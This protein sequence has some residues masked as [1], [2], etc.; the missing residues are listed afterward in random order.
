MTGD[1]RGIRRR[2]AVGDERDGAGGGL[3]LGGICPGTRASTLGR[4][5]DE[6]VAHVQGESELEDADGN[7]QEQPGDHDELGHGRPTL[8][9]PGPR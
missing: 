2:Q 9:R 7:E 5:G 4:A 1:L 3:A 8:A 6:G